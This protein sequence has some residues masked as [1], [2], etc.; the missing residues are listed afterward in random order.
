M[1]IRWSTPVL[2]FALYA[3][4]AFAQEPKTKVGI[5]SPDAVKVLQKGLH[6]QAAAKTN[7]AEVGFLVRTRIDSIGY[8]DASKKEIEVKGVRLDYS[9]FG[10]KMENWND[11][12]PPVLDSLV[13]KHINTTAEAKLTADL[14]RGFAN[15]DLPDQPHVAMQAA[16]NKKNL[17]EVYF[18]SSSFNVAGELQIAGLVGK[19]VNRQALDKTI[20]AELDGKPAVRAK[21]GPFANADRLNLS[22]IKE[23][24]WTLG[25]NALQ[26]WLASRAKDGLDQFRIDRFEYAYQQPGEKDDKIVRLFVKIKLV[27]LTGDAKTDVNIHEKLSD[28]ILGRN[29][30]AFTKPIASLPAAERREPIVDKPD[31][32]VFAC[33]AERTKLQTAIASRNDLDGTLVWGKARFDSTGR[34]ELNGVWRGGAK[35]TA[36]LESKLKEVLAKQNDRLASEGVST[37]R[38]VAIDTQTVLADLGDW[39]AANLDDVRVE[40]VYFDSA[41]KLMLKATASNK[42]DAAK[43][44]SQF[45]SLLARYDILKR[46]D[47]SRAALV[48]SAAPG[49]KAAPAEAGVSI[50]NFAASLTADLQKFLAEHAREDKWRGILIGRGFFDRRQDNR[51]SLSVIVD[52]V[53][54]ESTVRDLVKEFA[55]K[56]AYAGYL[57]SN[58][59]PILSVEEISLRKLVAHL[60]D[61]MPANPHFDGFRVDDAVHDAQRNLVLIVAGVGTPDDLEP[62]AKE[63]DPIGAIRQTLKKMLDEHSVWKKRSAVRADSKLVLVYGNPTG[64]VPFNYDLGRLAAVHGARG[65]LTDTGELRTRV[66]TALMHNPNNSALWYLSA[67]FHVIDKRED[68]ALRDLRRVVLIEKD[69]DIDDFAVQAK[70]ARI[71]ILEPFQGTTRHRVEKLLDKAYLD[72]QANKQ[73]PA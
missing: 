36:A 70:K 33:A 42:D 27:E 65:I 72:Y 7:P 62:K 59:N 1:P 35:G 4:P 68:L 23:A 22:G 32:T 14:A 20:R 61:V 48:S 73:P 67:G 3:L 47:E 66:R 21:S 50:G 5:D 18:A 39:T 44:E 15:I 26:A 56:P 71:S 57:A 64:P 34:L 41:G 51:Y 46:V 45:R 10:M 29:W 38:F 60:R 19:S 24:D 37:A 43:L 11:I 16:A 30:E 9:G 12:V 40:R 25:R 55:A 28:Q 13:K 53:K 31:R 52:D 69:P 54:Q 8:K 49:E 17:D 58:E 2:L 6:D 63:P